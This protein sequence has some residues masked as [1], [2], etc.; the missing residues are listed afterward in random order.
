[1]ELH[2][3][4]LRIIPLNLEHFRL[5]LDGMYKMEHALGLKSS[6]L[7]LDEE[8]QKAMANLY[9]QALDNRDKYLWYTNWQIILKDEIVS[10][11]SACFKGA[12][13]I[14]GEVEIGYGLNDNYRGRGYMAEAIKAIVIWALE[15]ENVF[16]VVAETEKDNIASQ[17]VL[18]RSG[19]HRYKE[20]DKSLFWC[21]TRQP[22]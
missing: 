14:T 2:T 11:G 7:L 17:K 15:Q 6:G 13:D 9:K 21:L 1:L 18:W 3:E 4:R 19:F 10:I 5:M 20:D 22:D 8:T 16:R 12:P